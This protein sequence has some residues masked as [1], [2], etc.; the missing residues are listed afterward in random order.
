MHSF[1]KHVISRYIIG[2]T[3]VRRHVVVVVGG[4]V[5]VR[6]MVVALV[7]CCGHIENRSKLLLCT[8]SFALFEAKTLSSEASSV[9]TTT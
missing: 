1:A 7:C 8:C 6:V 4:A 9:T 5:V 2:C 3:F